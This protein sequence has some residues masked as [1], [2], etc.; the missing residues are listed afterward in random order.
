MMLSRMCWLKNHQSRATKTQHM[1]PILPA[2][3]AFGLVLLVSVSVSASS[4]WHLAA[5]LSVAHLPK[6]MLYICLYACRNN[7]T[8][9]Q[10]KVHLTETAQNGPRLRRRCLQA[11]PVSMFQSYGAARVVQWVK[12]LISFLSL[13]DYATDRAY[14]ISINT[15]ICWVD[16]AQWAQIWPKPRDHSLQVGVGAYLWMLQE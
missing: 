10:T 1:G 2:E 14:A 8:V 12:I 3:G 15:W 7:C 5:P 16:L 13:L 4:F 6:V 9:A 11:I